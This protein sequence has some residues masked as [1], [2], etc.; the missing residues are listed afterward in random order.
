MRSLL[1]NTG[2]ALLVF[3]LPLRAQSNKLQDSIPYMKLVLENNPTLRAAREA[4]QMEILQASTGNTP[5][6]PEI[7]FGYLFGKP[8]E[9]GNRIDFS[10][11]Q[12]VDFPTTYIHRS[13][14]RKIR[15]SLAELEYM[16]VR[17]E[18]LLKARELW[19]EGIYLNN[20]LELL[21]ERLSGAREIQ[22]G[23]LQKVAAG[24]EG[25]LSLNQARLHLLNLEAEY[26][27]VRTDIQDNQLSLNEITGGSD[28][29]ITTSL[30]PLGS[31]II[32]DSIL[33][34]YLQSPE[35][36]L[37][38]QE[39]ELK[40]EEKNL[41]V[42]QNLPGISTGYYSESV[43]DQ[44]FKGFHIGITVP[45]WENANK[46]KN[47]R[48]EVIFAEVD[49]ERFNAQQEKA[50]L[51]K[52]NQLENLDTRIELF[53]EALEEGN[54][55]EL[56]A[57]SMQSG[58]ISLTEYFYSSD[59]HFRNQQLLLEYRKERLLLEAKLLKVYL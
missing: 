16:S 45:L 15:S 12:Q 10:V 11:N 34:A 17:Q 2:L 31:T 58:E 13:R 52:L 37:Y 50:V 23:F 57:F 44:K 55:M 39:L 38:Q 20:H 43:L 48:S 8:V 22:Q 35:L 1:I 25:Q 56:L 28:Q 18:I 24:E 30:L 9:M 46:I 33:A 6:D 7:E 27:Q 51:Q 41:A 53:E 26:E 3:A 32:G 5:P 42:S 14:V 54:T 49:L 47:A 36:L 21:E 59:F 29:Q 4:Y 19:I 40:K